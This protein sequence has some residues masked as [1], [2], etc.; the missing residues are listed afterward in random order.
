MAAMKTL[1]VCLVDVGKTMQDPICSHGPSKLDTALTLIG[2]LTTQCIMASKT[3]EYAVVT[4]GSNKTHNA[5]NKTCKGYE[6]VEE[7]LPMGCQTLSSITEVYGIEGTN[8]P[9][10]SSMELLCHRIF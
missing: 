4:F 5:L 1:M 8:N 2:S 7:V 3:V 6:G 9:S 10:V